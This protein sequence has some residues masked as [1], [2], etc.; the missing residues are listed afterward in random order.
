MM[1]FEQFISEYK[2]ERKGADSSQT[3][4]E[5]YVRHVRYWREWLTENRDKTLWEAD[6]IDLRVFIKELDRN[7]MASSTIS[8]KVS[9][10]SKF[11]QDAVTIVEEQKEEGRD[12]PDIPDNPYD[13]L[14]KKY[15][16]RLNG[17]T[18]KKQSMSENGGDEY[19]YLEPEK[20]K[21]LIEN[22]PAPRIRNEL[23][24]KLLYN[25]GFRRG[26]LANVKIDHVDP[27]D[28]SIFIPAQKSPEP[29]YVPYNEDFVGFQ[30][31]QWL[32]YG[33][34]DSMTYAPNSEY[35]FPTNSKEQISKDYIN[36]I[37]KRA[38]ES[39]G[40][41]EITAEYSN[42]RKQHKITA[43]TLRHSFAMQM[44]DAKDV[45]IRTL[46][47]LL[48]HE[49]LDTTLIYLQQSKEEAKEAGR[50]FQPGI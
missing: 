5:R 43:H 3:T 26:E 46:Q 17:D 10:I 18:K 49:K 36:R 1:D 20:V 15:K 19:P 9:A 11:Y 32:E 50:T 13:N 44:L 30:L 14:R 34:R 31:N 47:T 21:Q 12:V 39:A 29:R 16:S 35:L 7:N 42:G 28:R 4:I 27:D 6:N 41:Q 33:G 24:V 23:I 45:N 8:Q 37:V 48:G 38:A 40:L 25:C 2:K 22:V